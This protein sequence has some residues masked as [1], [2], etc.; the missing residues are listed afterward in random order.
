LVLK[1]AAIGATFRDNGPED[2]VYSQLS[3]G[4]KHRP[5]VSNR[6]QFIWLL[7]RPIFKM[8]KLENACFK[9]LMYCKL[10]KLIIAL[11]KIDA[12]RMWKPPPFNTWR[13]TAIPHCF[14]LIFWAVRKTY[15]LFTRI[16]HFRPAVDA[17]GENWRLACLK[18][19][20]DPSIVISLMI[21]DVRK[22]KGPWGRH[23]INML[24]LTL[25]GCSPLPKRSIWYLIGLQ[26]GA[27]GRWG[28]ELT[29]IPFARASVYSFK[30]CP[31]VISARCQWEKAWHW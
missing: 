13:P 3:V 18:R 29:P 20:V 24:I 17:L 28:D 23:P 6:I 9:I 2:S 5:R 31:C 30:K 16:A 26:L 15:T 12:R 1:T 4:D 7:Y 19:A 10:Y 14:S 22:L 21:C 27:W 8:S 11:A 25:M